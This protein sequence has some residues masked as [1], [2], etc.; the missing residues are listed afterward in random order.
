MKSIVQVTR[1]RE[2]DAVI[3]TF[4]RAQP[5]AELFGDKHASSR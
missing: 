2:L 3:N 5:H 4:V 1:K